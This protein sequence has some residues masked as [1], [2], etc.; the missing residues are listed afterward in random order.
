[1]LGFVIGLVDGLI[2]ISGLVGLC[3]RINCRAHV[4]YGLLWARHCAMLMR[5][6]ALRAFFRSLRADP[7]PQQPC[8]P[9]RESPWQNLH[10]TLLGGISGKD[11]DRPAQVAR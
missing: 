11:P 9:L 7:W 5:R 10:P 8:H 3:N 6:Y 2:W 4:D 1:M